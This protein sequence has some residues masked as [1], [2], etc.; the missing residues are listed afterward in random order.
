MIYCD[1]NISDTY[2]HA[3]SVFYPRMKHLPIDVCLILNLVQDGV[4]HV[5]RVSS[6]DQ[7]VDAL[8]KPL[9][10]T[11]IDLQLRRRGHECN[12]KEAMITIPDF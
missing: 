9:P 5:T 11:I 6:V 8:T 1:Y 12:S 7:V 4:L 3:D 10:R 2:L